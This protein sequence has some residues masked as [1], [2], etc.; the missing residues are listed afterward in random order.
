MHIAKIIDTLRSMKP[1]L[2]TET[3]EVSLDN[4]VLRYYGIYFEKAQAVDLTD[5]FFDALAAQW[6][7][8]QV[9]LTQRQQQVYDALTDAFSNGYRIAERAGI[10]T[11]SP[12]ETAAKFCIQLVD[13]GLAEKGGSPQF[14]EWRRAQPK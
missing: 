1:N 9:V 12:R 2:D 11:S 7:A 14:P 4:M 5:R 13:L 6:S 8:Q 10:T 3:P